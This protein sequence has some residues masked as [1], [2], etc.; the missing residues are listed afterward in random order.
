MPQAKD[1]VNKCSLKVYLAWAGTDRYDTAL[2]SSNMM[3]SKVRPPCPKPSCDWHAPPLPHLHASTPPRLLASSPPWHLIGMPMLDYATVRPCGMRVAVA[4]LSDLEHVPVYANGSWQR[5][6][7]IFGIRRK[8]GALGT[9]NC[10]QARPAV[11]LPLL[12]LP[13]ALNLTARQGL[14]ASAAA[15]P[16]SVPI[17]CGHPYSCV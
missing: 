15:C 6:L 10:P 9:C 1:E 3:F 11:S 7:A 12:L 4:S 14:R 8:H 13:Q 17:S 2:E 16:C 5:R